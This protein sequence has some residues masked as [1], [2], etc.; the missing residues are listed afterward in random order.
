MNNISGQL[1]KSLLLIHECHMLPSAI[2]I[3][4]YMKI[5]THFNEW[6]HSSLLTFTL[7]TQHFFL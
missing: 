3:K 4:I 6:I 2:I 7:H 1:L 5:I